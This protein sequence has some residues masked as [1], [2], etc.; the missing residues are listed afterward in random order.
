MT[1]VNDSSQS[2]SVILWTALMI[3]I[4]Q[5]VSKQLKLINLSSPVKYFCGMKNDPKSCT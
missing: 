3:Q 5:S 4:F 2:S 1:F